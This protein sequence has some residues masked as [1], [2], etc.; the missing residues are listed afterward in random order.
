[1]KD[2]RKRE[3]LNPQKILKCLI[4][5]TKGLRSLN[6]DTD[7]DCPRLNKENKLPFLQ[8]LMS[9]VWD[10]LACH[11]D[12]SMQK[13][14]ATAGHRICAGLSSAPRQ[15]IYAFKSKCFSEQSKPAVPATTRQ[16]E[17][18][19]LW[20]LP[21]VLLPGVPPLLPGVPPLLPAAAPQAGGWGGGEGGRP[22]PFGQPEGALRGM[23][24]WR[25]ALRNWLGKRKRRRRRREANTPPP[26][27]SHAKPTHPG[28]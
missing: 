13:E 7:L 27:K 1:M 20:E 11:R 21:G 18:G 14:D 28:A 15:R 23:A 17:G 9:L 5:S 24:S 8:K 26:P 4:S 19:G 25:P 16:R 22:S 3:L 10:R 2:N 12:T 6:T